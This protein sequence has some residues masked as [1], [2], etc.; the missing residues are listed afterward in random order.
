MQFFPHKRPVPKTSSVGAAIIAARALTEALTNPAPA[1]PFYQFGD[2]QQQAI[3]DLAKIFESAIAKPALPTSVPPRPALRKIP[4]PPLRVTI[5]PASPR[6]T[7]PPTSLRVNIPPPAPRVTLPLTDSPPSPLTVSP[8]LHL[9]AIEPDHQGE[10]STPL[11]SPATAS[12]RTTRN[13]TLPRRSR[14]IFQLPPAPWPSHPVFL[15]EPAPDMPKPL[16]TSLLPS[17]A[18][19]TTP[20]P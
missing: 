16:S 4:P 20:T 11:L 1:A 5:P 12:G 2:A 10:K 14:I 13:N 17:T 18:T 6:V 3:I 15:L 7:V 9:H 19:Q 8:P